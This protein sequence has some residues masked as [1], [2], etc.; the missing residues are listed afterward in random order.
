MTIEIIINRKSDLPIHIQK[1]FDYTIMKHQ[2]L[3]PFAD[4]LQNILFDEDFIDKALD[5]KVVK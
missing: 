4:Y 3:Y 2:D 1:D 5:K